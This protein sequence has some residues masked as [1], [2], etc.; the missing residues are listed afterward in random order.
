MYEKLSM[1]FILLFMILIN[2][3]KSEINLQEEYPVLSVWV[4]T[5]IVIAKDI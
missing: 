5:H 3:N 1:N 4:V 2:F